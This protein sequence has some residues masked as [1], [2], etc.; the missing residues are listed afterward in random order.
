MS[1]GPRVSIVVPSL[2]QGRFLRE[3]LDS[4]LD[5]DY[6]NLETVV[7]DGGS[8]DG[9]VEILRAYGD[10]VSFVSAA[11]AGQ[12]DAIN[13]GWQRTSGSI[14][15]WLNA[16]DRYLPGAIRKAVAALEAHPNAAMVYGEGELIDEAGRLR[17]SFPVTRPFDLWALM[18]VT[19]YIMQPTVFM[20]RSCVEACG[21]LQ[22]HLH[23]GLDWDLW[24]RL[25]CRWPI[26]YLPEA[27]AQAREHGQTKTSTG[28]FRRLRELW[29]ILAAH[30]VSPWSAAAVG[31]SYDTLRRW[32]TVVLGSPKALTTL[33]APL[34]RIGARLR[35]GQGVFRD[36]WIAPRAF[37]A[38]PWDGSP[39]RLKIRAELPPDP[40]LL[41]FELEVRA[42]SQAI[43]VVRSEPGP[44][45]VDLCL[46]GRPASHRGPLELELRSS[47]RRRSE[48]G[49]RSVSCLLHEVALAHATSPDGDPPSV[50][51]S[52]SEGTRRGHP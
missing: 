34:A 20:R 26:V 33:L 5:Q 16:D 42:A 3:A 22:A 31:F 49:G 40:R 19:D 28:G 39:A 7:M 13:R 48:A 4:I 21:G 45:R 10:R 41:P 8:T 12:A 46:R 47:R 32:L 50:A 43:R 30:G 15:A 51:W 36:G 25:G 17:G 18:H 6:P 24:I 9:S 14:V 23:Y 27:L 11:D 38:L 52:P 29:T 37:C 1:G 35:S 44:F 2:N